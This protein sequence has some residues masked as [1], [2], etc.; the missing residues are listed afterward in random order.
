MDCSGRPVGE[1]GEWACPPVGEWACP[2][3]VW[4]GDQRAAPRWAGDT[5]TSVTELFRKSAQEGERFR[6]LIR[7]RHGQS[8][9]I[10]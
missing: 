2:L 10:R 7:R 3:V 6:Q 4:S 9:S 8:S 5:F 1:C